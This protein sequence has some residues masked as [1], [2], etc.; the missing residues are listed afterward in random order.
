MSEFK[1]AEL[2]SAIDLLLALQHH[3]SLRAIHSSFKYPLATY[4][5]QGTVVGGTQNR[6]GEDTVS[7]K[8]LR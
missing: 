8:T 1:G 6:D 7:V 5:R 3:H 4:V 2:N